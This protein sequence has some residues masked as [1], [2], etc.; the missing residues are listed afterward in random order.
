MWYR[1]VLFWAHKK[2][3]RHLR[4]VY[5]YSILTKNQ[6]HLVSTM[7]ENMQRGKP[8]RKPVS[9]ITSQIYVCGTN[10]CGL[11]LAIETYSTRHTISADYHL[12]IH[13]GIHSKLC[14]ISIPTQRCWGRQE[15]IRN[16]LTHSSVA[17]F[18]DRHTMINTT[19]VVII[20]SGIYRWSK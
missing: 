2:Y 19:P 3:P 14:N 1:L 13:T 17:C 15:H 18:A 11:I 20:H 5:V 8:E 10:G 9:L 6:T 4:A 12:H 16:L 7:H